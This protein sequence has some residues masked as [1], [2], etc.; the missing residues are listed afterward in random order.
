MIV[1]IKLPEKVLIKARDL[2]LLEVCT[3]GLEKDVFYVRINL[4]SVHKGSVAMLRVKSS[5]ASAVGSIW[6]CPSTT[7]FIIAKST[8]LSATF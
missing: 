8:E 7:E 1:D 4:E 3:T 2:P 6:Y 5:N